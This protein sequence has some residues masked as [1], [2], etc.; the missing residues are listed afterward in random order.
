M[1]PRPRHVGILA[2]TRAWGGAE[3]HTATVARELAARGARVTILELAGGQYL[4]RAGRH[5]LAGV[6]VV[7][8]QVPPIKVRKSADWR[9][10][11]RD[12]GLDIVVFPKGHYEL[13]WPALHLGALRARVRYIEIEHSTPPPPAEGS[14]GWRRWLRRSVHRRALSRCIAVCEA[15]AE[16]LTASYRYPR[17]RIVVIPNGVDFARFSFSR[18][19]RHEVRARLGLPDE[20]LLVGVIARLAPE[21]RLD[22]LIRAFANLRTADPDR[23]MALLMI[24]EGPSGDELRALGDA[25]GHTATI[26]WP[27][28]AERPEE[29]LSAIDVFALS[30]ALEASPYSLLEAMACE[31][32]VL[33]TAVG[34]ID[35]VIVPGVNGF[36]ADA[37]D[38]AFSAALARV[39]ALT[40]EERARIGAD[41]RRT[42]ERSHDARLQVPRV[43]SA[44]L[45]DP[46]HAAIA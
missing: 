46:H 12:H 8:E 18:S 31:R 38:S 25:L 35:E 29:W 32:V 33:S 11:F 7:D 40:P 45:P 41:A 36:L 5:E 39:C 20:T 16:I 23:S 4:A 21:K 6:G 10:L 30:S 44:I 26:H 9:D 15:T 1:P 17:S 19:R 37:D 42:V 22:R 43:A 24:G 13:D 3:L 2:V 27:G 34:G 28:W 14:A